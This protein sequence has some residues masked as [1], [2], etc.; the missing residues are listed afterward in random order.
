MPRNPIFRPKKVKLA[1][2]L[3]AVARHNSSITV[4]METARPVDKA[5]H[6]QIESTRL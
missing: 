2:S 4:N 1:V 6:K 5:I 3:H